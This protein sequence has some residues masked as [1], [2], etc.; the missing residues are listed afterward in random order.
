MSPAPRGHPPGIPHMDLAA[1]KD[2][3]RN[4]TFGNQI[5]EEERSVLKGL[6]CQ[7]SGVGENI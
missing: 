5:A 6:F 2:A 4:L 3:I 1:K 7:N